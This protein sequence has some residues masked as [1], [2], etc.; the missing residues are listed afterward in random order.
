MPRPRKTSAPGSDAAAPEDG[1]PDSAAPEAATALDIES[2]AVDAVDRDDG[3]A[4]DDNEAV[5]SGSTS[6][7]ADATDDDTEDDPPEVEAAPTE[8]LPSLVEA[9]LFVSDGP[10][11]LRSLARALGI[12]MTALAPA[13][14]DLR[15]RLEGRGL[16]LQTGPDGAQLVTAPHAAQYVEAFLGL[17]QHRRLSNAALETLAIIAYRQPVTRATIES[18]RGVSS[19]GAMQTLRARGLVEEAGR[20]PAPGRPTLF[21]TTQRF[22]EHFGMN[23]PQDLPPLGDADLPLPDASIPMPGLDGR[24][25]PSGDNH[26][27]EQVAAAL[28]AL[29][30]AARSL[31]DPGQRRAGATALLLPGPT[32][33]SLP[34]PAAAHPEPARPRLPEQ[35]AVP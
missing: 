9:L 8:A 31:A 35:R 34:A 28:A 16:I 4:H 19:D 29:S 15:A 26:P 11:E 30:A 6:R 23:G 13:L 2:A 20:S 33:L 24:P 5:S 14:E 27:I 12:T 10:V 32:V 7:A 21:A 22:L 18:I 25:L 17:E 3:L 1:P